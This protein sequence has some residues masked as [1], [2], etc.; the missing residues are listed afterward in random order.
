[1]AEFTD[2]VSRSSQHDN[3]SSDESDIEFISSQTQTLTYSPVT[4][5][6]GELLCKKLMIPCKLEPAV[7]T[8][9]DLGEPCY[10]HKILGDGNCFFR[11]IS[12]AICGTQ[13]YHGVIRDAIVR[14]ILRNDHMYRGFFKKGV[15]FNIKIY[16]S[17]K[18]G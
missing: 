18:D 2:C 12:K 13:M 14:R 17:V 3:E 15:Q 6:V 1:M 16:P 11:S 7:N 8:I 5:E 10:N 9:L 4:F